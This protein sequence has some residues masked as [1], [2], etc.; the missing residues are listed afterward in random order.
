[1][2][3]RPRVPRRLSVGVLSALG[4]PIALLIA[5]AVV[6]PCCG[7]PPGAQAGRGA[8]R[9]EA[10]R[11][12]AA[13]RLV[14]AYHYPWYGYK[15]PDAW[16]RKTADH[17]LLGAYRSADPKLIDFQLSLASDAGIDGFV[18]SWGGPDTEQEEI[19]SQMLDEL[20]RS[21]RGRFRLSVICE[22][23]AGKSDLD[24]GKVERDL[25]HLLR[26]HGKRKAF[27]RADGRPVAFVYTPQGWPAERWREVFGAVAREEGKALWV[28]LA[29]G[30]EFDL[31]YLAAFDAFAPYAD[32][33]YADETLRKAYRRLGERVREAKSPLIVAAIGG[34]SRVQK[35]GFDIDRSEGR[36]LRRRFELAKELGADWVAITSWNEWYES[37]QI[38]PSREH[39]FEQVRH[40]RELAFAFKGLAAP[41]LGGAALAVSEKRVD[42]WAE[43]TATN[44]GA[45]TL[46]YVTAARAGK[47]PA[48]VAY[49]LHPAESA[50]A[51]LEGSAPAVT[52]V[53]PDGTTVRAGK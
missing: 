9:A 43:V 28:A 48:I 33:Y 40:V 24:S 52:A 39:G 51:S 5:L 8:A 38:E 49:V 20:E 19:L 47:D 50:S 12:G 41:P 30:W 26:R 2:T 42:G 32:K 22:A 31:G 11:G 3:D 29:D 4:G 10:G 23:Y 17:P 36:Y 16:D 35:L 45:R 14:L 53:L 44:T 34:G 46:Y 1:M 27:L 21:P 13:G 25:L 6:S 15:A 7:D 37:M 18:V